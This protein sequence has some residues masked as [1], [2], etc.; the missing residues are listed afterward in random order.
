M[1]I[2]RFDAATFASLH[3]ETGGEIA[4]VAQALGISKGY[5][6]AARL[7]LGLPVRPRPPAKKRSS[8]G[9]YQKPRAVRM[10]RACMSCR[11]AFMSEGVHNRLCGRCKC[12]DSPQMMEGW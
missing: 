11:R 12:E 8:A 10:S 1:T 5:A 7:S 2:A 6:N 4:A 3:A 9:N